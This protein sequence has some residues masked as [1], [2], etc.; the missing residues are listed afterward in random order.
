M[1]KGGN[2]SSMGKAYR[3]LFGTS[4]ESV[5]G[6]DEWYATHDPRYNYSTPLP[7]VEEKGYI[8][9]GINETTGKANTIP[10]DPMLRW[11]NI[12]AKEI[13]TEWLL[14][15]TNIRMRELVLS[16]SLPG[17]M[18]SKT[19]FNNV[20]VSFVG[21]N[22]FFFYNAMKDIDPESGYSSGNT[23]GGFEHSAIPTLRSYGFNFKVSF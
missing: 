13:G 14:D 20:Q 7:G 4:E 3:G 11:Y 22:L 16:Y 6:R 12:W 10:V 18:I 1:R 8:E 15:A 9:D 5:A 21:R 2:V 17:N 23:G 19:P